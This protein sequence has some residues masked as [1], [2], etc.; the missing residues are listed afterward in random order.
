MEI[1]L[2]AYLITGY[3]W[4]SVVGPFL[5]YYPQYH[6]MKKN[7]SVGSF[8][9]IICYVMFFSA[10]L[11]I[12]YFFGHQYDFCLFLQSCVMLFIQAFLLKECL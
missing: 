4:F 5:N 3:T 9:K 10:I 6:L 2:K 8:N 7:N 1:E 12:I 11:R